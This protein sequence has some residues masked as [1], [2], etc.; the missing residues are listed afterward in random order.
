[1]DKDSLKDHIRTLGV[2]AG[3]VNPQSHWVPIPG[4]AYDEMHPAIRMQR[5]G[6]RSEHLK[7]FSIGGDKVVHINRGKEIQRRKQMG[8]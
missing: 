5:S 7:N 4:K 3:L 2:K 8:G 6:D 1:M